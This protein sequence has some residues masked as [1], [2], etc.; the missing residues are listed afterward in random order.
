MTRSRNGWRVWLVGMLAGV[1]GCGGDSPEAEQPNIIL[2]ITDDQGYGD[3]G[4]HGNPVIETPHLDALAARSARMDN[5]YVSPVCAPTRA[6][7]MT[8]RYNYRTRV[9]DTYLGRAMM[10]PA[11]ITLAE[12]LRDAGYATG[13][14]GKWHLGDAYPMRPG[15]QGFEESLVHRGGGIGQPSDPPGGERKYTDAVLFHDGEPVP[16]SGY[17]TDVYFDAALDW[18]EKSHR[19]NRPF[20][21]YIATNAPH[22]PFHDVPDRLY[23][24]YRA[25]DLSPSS[26][27]HEDGHAL[28][29][30]WDVDLLARIF[31]MIGNVD[32]NV[33]QLQEKLE[34][35]GLAN[36]TIVVFLLDNGP[37]TRRYVAGM[38]GRKADVYEGGIRSP[39]WIQWPAEL[40]PGRT[41]DRIS[42]H[43]DVLPT[44]LEAAGIALPD[45]ARIDGRSLLPLLRGDEVDWPDRTLVI[46]GHRGDVPVRYHHFM[47]RTQRWK[48]LNASGFHLDSLPSQPRFELYDMAADPLETEDVAGR[49]PEVAEQIRQAYDAWFDSVSNTRP[50]NYEPAFIE[51]GTPHESPTI[52][53]RQDWRSDP[54]RPA[55]WQRNARGHWRVR[56]TPGTYDLLLRFDPGPE[57]ERITLDAGSVRREAEV[58]PDS[59]V[60]RFDSVEIEGGKARVEAYLTH[61]S[62]V[63]GVH[64]VE[65]RK[66]E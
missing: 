52:L 42:A 21:A 50:D 15:D 41:S 56:F 16:T 60:F 64:Q 2:L 24:K 48:L 53:T 37:N 45:E 65:I 62:T 51:I 1:L 54:D 32:E 22:G 31:A 8:G 61:G 3:F 7:L 35:T 23:E 10:E 9:V 11:E 19:E 26:F 57:A 14:F 12:Y 44:L 38:R 39:L 49:H 20:F 5:F 4:F 43:I 36:N 30:E 13:I 6:S 18:I 33:G 46:Q 59:A 25:M 47:A 28:P 27:R 63:R 55:G 66:Q 40:E 34:E 17:C 29:Q 58:A